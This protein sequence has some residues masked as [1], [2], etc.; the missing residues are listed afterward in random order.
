[1]NILI[2]N[3]TLLSM[4]DKE[5]PVEN[6]EVAIEKDKI[7]YI[8]EV[9]E[10]F[11]A[12]KVIDARESLVMPGLIDG[13]THIAMSLFRN[14]ADDLPLMEWLKTRIWPLEEKLTAQDVYWGSMLG[15]AELIR[16]GVTCFSDM[17]FFMEETAKAVEEA[18]IRAVLA[19]GLV[20]GDNDDGRRFEETRKLYKSWH[21]GAGGRIKVMVGPHAPYTCSPGY[22]RKVVEL[23][24]E[25]NVGIHIHIAESAD[26]VEESLKNYGKSPVRH[27]Y[28]LGLF[29]IPTVAAHCVHLSDEDIEILAENKVSVVNNPTSNLKLASGFAPVEKMIKKGINVALGTDGPSSNNNLNMFEEINLAAIINKSVNHDATSIP[30]ITAIKMATV[31]GAKALGLEKEIASIEVGKKADLIIID[32]QKPHF[33]PRHNI[34]SAVAYSAQA[35]DVKTVIVDGKIVM[36]DYEIKTIDT[37]RIMFETEKAAKDLMRR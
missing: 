33:Y 27:I 1:M 7:K 35:S 8:G 18:G 28:D 17:Y 9:P 11:Y 3:A 23:A 19:R 30:A 34:I 14:Y 13:H 29:D 20:G 10:D 25:L 5:E 22:L 2:K 4:G 21:N 16:S 12:E 15:V 37:E 24:R 26:E 36:E 6:V 32:T 31:N